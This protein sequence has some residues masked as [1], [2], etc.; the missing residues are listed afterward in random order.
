MTA[1]GETPIPNKTVAVSRDLK[2]LLGKYIFI[3]GYGIRYVNDLMAP[4]WKNKID[5]HMSTKD[6]AFK[7]GVKEIK[8]CVIGD[9]LTSEYLNEFL[10]EDVKDGIPAK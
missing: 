8:Y 5:V 3:D 4:R 1:T 6:E 7:H 9:Q 10:L 2:K